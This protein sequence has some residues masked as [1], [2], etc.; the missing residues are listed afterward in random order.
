MVTLVGS[1]SDDGV[2]AVRYHA[3]GAY[4]KIIYLVK[5]NESSH[6]PLMLHT[7]PS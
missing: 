6:G 4:A 5:I 2:S 7:L 1:Y 3:L